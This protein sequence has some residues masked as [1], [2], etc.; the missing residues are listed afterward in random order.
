[1]TRTRDQWTATATGD[2]AY[3]I[4]VTSDIFDPDN[5]E[6]GMLPEGHEPGGTRLV[7]MDEQAAEL[8]GDRIRRYFA[9]NDIA[10]EYLTLRGGDE[11][12]PVDALVQV[13]GRLSAAGDAGPVAPPTAIGGGALQDAVGMA[14][15]LYRRGIAYVRVPTTL[16]GQLDGS[17]PVQSDM[18]T[19]GC[20]TRPGAVAP[21]PRTLIDRS[22]LAPLSERQIRGGLGEALRM[23]LV[24]DARLF[25]LLEEYGPDLVADRLQDSGTQPGDPQPG[26]EVVHRAVAG[27]AEELR[28]NLSDTGR[29]GIADYGHTFSPIVEMCALP[30]L[31][32]GEAVAMDCVFSAVLAANRGI[33]APRQLTRIVG[34]ARRI[35]LAPSHPVYTDAATMRQALADTVRPRDDRRSLMLLADIG[36]TAL[37]DDVTEAEIGRATR[38]MA[39]LLHEPQPHSRGGPRCESASGDPDE[40][41]YARPAGPDARAACTRLAA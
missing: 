37:V 24:K 5:P 13:A 40:P 36:R 1:M 25:A 39:D 28:R 8:F 31:H 23:A 38:C 32:H 7:V 15:G 41:T 18:T 21:P 3:E 20:R 30:E 22:L 16:I 33:L 26:L 6:L 11:H 17:L 34:T 27:V 9:G 2:S 4:V 12:R 35:G 14:A 19:R 29:R 10:T